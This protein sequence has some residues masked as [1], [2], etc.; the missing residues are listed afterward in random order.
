MTFQRI[1]HTHSN[2]VFGTYCSLHTQHNKE[3]VEEEKKIIKLEK[4]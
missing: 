3:A 1:E 2:I 4:S